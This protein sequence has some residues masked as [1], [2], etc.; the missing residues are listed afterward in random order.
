MKEPVIH[1][2]GPAVEVPDMLLA[3]DGRAAAQK[4][5]LERYHKPLLFFTQNIPG[6]VKTSVLIHLGFL[7]GIPILFQKVI[8]WKT[9]YE[10]YYVLDGDALRIKKIAC[11][12]EG[13]DRLGRLYDM[14]VLAEDGHKI[15]RTDIGLPG[16]LCLVCS[17]PAQAC[18]R[19]RKHSVPVLVRNIHRIL[20]NFLMDRVEQALRQ[21]LQGGGD[22]TIRAPTGIWTGTPLSGVLTPLCPIS[23]RWLK[24]AGT[25]KGRTKPCL[26]PSGPWGRRRKRP[27][28]GLPGM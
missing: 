20:E 28:S 2:A 15:S 21:G 1:L 23:G 14:D 5:L 10:K 18:A 16:R 9:G 19:S 27:C 3:R 11:T 25:G 26:P 7:A 17:Q 24:K 12:M 22:G 4:K 6:P 13:Q 8:D